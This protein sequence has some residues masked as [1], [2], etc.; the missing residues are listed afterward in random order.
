MLEFCCGEF[1]KPHDAGINFQSKAP[2]TSYFFPI[3]LYFHLLEFFVPYY[4]LPQELTWY[5]EVFMWILPKT[6]L[7]KF[8]PS[9]H[10]PPPCK[11]NEH[12]GSLSHWIFSLTT[13]V[14][15]FSVRPTN[16]VLIHLPYLEALIH[17][18]TLPQFSIMLTVVC[19]EQF[20]FMIAHSSCSQV[21]TSHNGKKPE[22]KSKNVN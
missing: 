13:K 15:Q 17:E 22:K 9:P 6:I 3:S 12:A 5:H 10:P 11:I 2:F 21:A 7:K 20:F 1:N 8:L 19:E 16:C 14:S 18:K 4:F